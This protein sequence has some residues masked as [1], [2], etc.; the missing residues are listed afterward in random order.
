MERKI[1]ELPR[2]FLHG[3]GLKPDQWLTG[4]IFLRKDIPD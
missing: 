1:K 4:R 3:E 2:T